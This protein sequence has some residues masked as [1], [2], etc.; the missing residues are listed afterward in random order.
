VALLQHSVLTRIE[1]EIKRWRNSNMTTTPGTIDALRTVFRTAVKSDATEIRALKL[2]VRVAQ[3][4]QSAD[5]PALHSGL[6]ALRRA[7]RVRHVA[8]S[9][10]KGRRWAEIEKNHP[11]GDPRLGALIANAWTKAARE[12]GEDGQPPQSLRQY[13]EKW[14]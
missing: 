2:R 3:R 4:A 6:T 9:L 14:L 7:A 8:Y 1:L 13:I 5:A 12:A 10:W 11:D